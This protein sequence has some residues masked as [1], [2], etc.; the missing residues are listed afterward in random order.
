MFG[1]DAKTV[2]G[3]KELDNSE[4]DAI[5]NAAANRPDGLLSGTNMEAGL[6]EAENMLKA[7]QTNDERKYVIVVSDGLTRLF[8]GDDGNVKIIF[9]Q[10]EADG[11]RYFGE[12]TGWCVANG[13]G[14]GE[15]KVPGGDWDNYFDKVTG[16][17]KRVP[18]VSQTNS[19]FK[20]V[21]PVFS[22]STEVFTKASL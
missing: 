4:L 1:G 17:V 8:T 6:I 7:S 22:S 10:I 21:L 18:F 15:F 13:F 9:H 16:W 19:P 11:I 2:Y 5:Y 12:M 14:D 20:E 3:L